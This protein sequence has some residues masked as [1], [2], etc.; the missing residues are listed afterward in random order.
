MA[1]SDTLKMHVK[2]KANFTC[3]WC[4]DNSKKVEVHHIIPQ[5]ES[6]AD[7]ED[8]AAPLCSNCHS[9]YGG[10]PE[11]R[12]EIRARRD[13]WYRRCADEH[14]LV[15]KN[16]IY[17]IIQ[18]VKKGVS[19]EEQYEEKED[20]LQGVQ[21][22]Y[23][24]VENH[25]RQEIYKMTIPIDAQDKAGL[26]ALKRWKFTFTSTDPRISVVQG[27]ILGIGSTNGVTIGCAPIKPTSDCSVECELRILEDGND[28]S[29][30]AGIRVRGLYEDF[31]LGYLVYLRREGTVE[32]YRAEEIISR[33]KQRIVPDTEHTW[34][35]LRVDIVDSLI[36]VRVN[37]KMVLSKEDKWFGGMGNVYLHTFGTHSQFRNFRIY[38]LSY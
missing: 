7:T 4:T 22:L 36:S 27:G 37:G 15:A 11:L 35:K 28:A 19:L 30:W 13:N 1:F 12:K 33:T 31:R 18:Y 14:V 6:G 26:G 20:N 5:A 23:P 29:R 24:E 25:E 10:N 8:N 21:E 34:T 38:K 9:L 16:D 3:C 2:D 17:S 32:L